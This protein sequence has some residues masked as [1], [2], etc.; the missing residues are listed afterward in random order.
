[1]YILIIGNFPEETREKIRNAFPKEW[2]V[3][4]TEPKNVSSFLQVAEVVV[5]E[6]FRVDEQFLGSAP[7]LRMIQTGSGFDN[8]DLAACRKR[9]I[10][11]FSAPGVNAAAVAEHVMALML[12]WYKNIPYLDSFMKS[13]RDEKELDYAGGE[14]AG[15]TIGIIG[16]GHIGKK[17]ASLCSIFDMNV[18]GYSRKKTADSVIEMTEL[19][20]LLRRSDIITVHVPLTEESREMIGMAELAKMKKSALLINTSRGAVIEENA[21]IDALRKGQIAGACLD[22]FTEEPLSQ[23]SPLRDMKNVI[24]TP[25]T[26]GLPDGVKYHAKRYQYFVNN[27]KRFMEEQGETELIE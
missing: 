5:A 7:K 27:I 8:V 14:L 26:A 19:D 20:D 1:M 21:L 11:V 4:I 10:Q 3:T 13:H 12:S 22:V 9:G 25:H 6:H 18:L 16:T 2:T 23:E 15:K 17:V 24:L